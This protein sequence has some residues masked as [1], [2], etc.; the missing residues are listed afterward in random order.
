[1]DSKKT[2]IQTPNHDL[3]ANHASL[4]PHWSLDAKN[5]RHS[6]WCASVSIWSVVLTPMLHCPE[7]ATWHHDTLNPGTSP[8]MVKSLGLTLSPMSL[9]RCCKNP[10]DVND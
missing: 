2:V 10:R 1:M 6:L 8:S 3:E 9:L 4:D 7:Q 5:Y